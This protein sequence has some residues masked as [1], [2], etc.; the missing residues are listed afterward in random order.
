MALNRNCFLSVISCN[1]L[2]NFI[3]SKGLSIFIVTSKPKSWRLSIKIICNTQIVLSYFT[4]HLCVGLFLLMLLLNWLRKHIFIIAQVIKVDHLFFFWFL[5]LVSNN[6]HG[7]VIVKCIEVDH[8]VIS[9]LLFLRVGC[10]N[11]AVINI[12]L[13]I[14]CIFCVELLQVF[15][16][17]VAWY[18]LSD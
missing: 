4:N 11:P 18:T 8:I 13:K 5:F 14:C 12:F 1:V 15:D 7:L 3:T 2:E 6:L 10:F 17:F 16:S 9:L